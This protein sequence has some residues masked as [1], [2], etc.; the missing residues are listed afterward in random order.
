MILAHEK[1]NL[2]EK[3]ECSTSKVGPSQLPGAVQVKAPSQT[4]S[5]SQELV[6]PLGCFPKHK[7][8][9]G[10]LPLNMSSSSISTQGYIQPL[11]STS[12]AEGLG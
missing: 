5:C 1:A 4:M 12:T 6:R 8:P 11:T 10:L 3:T 7:P 9:V 2:G